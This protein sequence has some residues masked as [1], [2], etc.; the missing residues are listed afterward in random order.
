MALPA[1]LAGRP[2]LLNE[3]PHPFPLNPKPAAE[4]AVA[5]TREAH[6]ANTARNRESQRAS[7]TQ[8]G[9]DKWCEPQ[10]IYVSWRLG[11]R[12]ARGCH[13]AA[14]CWG[15]ALASLATPPTTAV[16]ASDPP[17]GCL[18]DQMR[19]LGSAAATAAAAAGPVHGQPGQFEG[20]M[21]IY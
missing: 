5:R 13:V 6:E 20:Q 11:G 21:D 7:K 1:T 10:N 3:G 16:T 14:T 9:S 15:L 12:S 2:A 18:R 19:R 17:D 8:K 4:G